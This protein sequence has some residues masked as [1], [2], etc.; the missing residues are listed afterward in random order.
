MLKELQEDATAPW[1]QRY[2]LPMTFAVQIAESLPERGLAV[3]NASGVFQL[4]AWEVPTG[5][6]TQ[7]TNRP[8]GVAFSSLSPDG[9]YVYYVLDQNQIVRIRRRVFRRA[10]PSRSRRHRWSQ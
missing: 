3:S 6:L 5:E 9:T 7:L 2:R 1:K 8:E 10:R 4:Y